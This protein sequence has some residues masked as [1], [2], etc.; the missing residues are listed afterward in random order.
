MTTTVLT[1]K[2]KAQIK[3]R[4]S[5]TGMTPTWTDAAVS[6]LNS[7][8]SSKGVASLTVQSSKPRHFA[9]W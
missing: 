6:A 5:D 3:Q 8:K 2:Q 4:G 9:N 1:N 7:R